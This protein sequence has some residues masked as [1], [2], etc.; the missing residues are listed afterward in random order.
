MLGFRFGPYVE[1]A[2]PLL[3]E[4]CAASGE[5]ESGTGKEGCLLALT[6]IVQFCTE[7]RHDFYAVCID[8]T[9]F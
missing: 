1:H 9:A 6:S 5:D 3:Q 8:I 7:V 4:R 2:V